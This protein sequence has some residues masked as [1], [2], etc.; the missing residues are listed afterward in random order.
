MAGVRSTEEVVDWVRN[1]GESSGEAH[2]GYCKAQSIKSGVCRMQ[3]I[4]RR[5]WSES[6]TDRGDLMDGFR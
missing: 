6:G 3:V 2:A 4:A 1:L 5:F